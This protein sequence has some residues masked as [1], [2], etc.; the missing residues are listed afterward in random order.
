M[1]MMNK[2]NVTDKGDWPT[3][4]AAKEQVFSLSKWDKKALALSRQFTLQT[5]LGYPETLSRVR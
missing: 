4:Q 5:V 3:E 1:R 2:K